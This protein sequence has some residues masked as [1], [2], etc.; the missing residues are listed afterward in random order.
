MARYESET[1][2]RLADSDAAGVLFFARQFVLAHEAFEEFMDAVG[3]GLG[4]LLATR[5]YLLPI[6]HAESDYLAPLRPGDRLKI[7]LSIARLGESSFTSQYEMT[8]AD[9]AAA[10][11]CRLVHV[12]IDPQGRGKIPL[13][14]SLRSALAPYCVD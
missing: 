14:G 4:A 11:S 13:P 9:G 6:V 5:S 2:I 12:A 1:T 7:S 8:R 10:G 3:C